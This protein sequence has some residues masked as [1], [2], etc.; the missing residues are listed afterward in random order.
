MRLV[1]VALALAVSAPPLAAEEG[2]ASQCLSYVNKDW[3]INDQ[4]G[5]E[6]DL[7]TWRTS[8][9]QALYADPENTKIMASLGNAWSSAGF[10]HISLPLTRAAAAKGDPDANFELYTLHQS[11]SRRLGRAPYVAREE[12]EKALRR[13]AELGHALAVQTLTRH[14]ERGTLVK[15]DLIEAALWAERSAK[16]PPRGSY[17]GDLDVIFGRI[18]VSLDDPAQR[19]RGLDLLA[20]LKRS[21]ASAHYADAIRATDPVRARKIYEDLLGAQEAHVAPPLADMLFKGEGG[22]ADRKRAVDLLDGGSWFGDSPA[23]RAHYGRLLVEG[24]HVTPDPQKGVDYMSYMT[25]WSIDWRHEVMGLLARHPDLRLKY[26]DG[27]FYD[28]VE[29]VEIG[30]PGAAMALVDLQLSANQQFRDLQ[31]GCALAEWA[32]GNGEEKAKARLKDCTAVPGTMR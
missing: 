5:F 30:E 11:F 13:S 12:A 3:D 8:C 24:R 28:A 14:L 26:P 27:M 7:K 16:N 32:A 23:L 17:P 20:G 18:L 9:Q 19:Q 22:P 15:R 25:Q 29:A 2:P 31:S 4:A 1:L 21:D 6:R 10:K